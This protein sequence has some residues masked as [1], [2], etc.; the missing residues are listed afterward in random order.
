MSVKR[1]SPL[2]LAAR[3]ACS[4]LF[5]GGGSCLAAS[6]SAGFG[7][8]CIV[9]HDGSVACWGEN[10]QGQA[11]Q[12]STSLVVAEPSIVA[13]LAGAVDLASGIGHS[14]ALLDMG[15]VRCWGR[16]E[17]GALGDGSTAHRAT[18][19]TVGTGTG[20]LSGVAGLGAGGLHT[21]ARLQDGSAACWGFNGSGQLGS[22]DIANHHDATPVAGLSD[23]AEIAAGLQHTCARVDDGRVFCWGSNSLGQLGRGAGGPSISP[24]PVTGIDDA[25]ALAARGDH[26]CVVRAGGEAWCWGSNE[27]RQ[28]GNGNA[29]TSDVPLRVTHVD[30]VNAIAAG[31]FNTCAVHDGGKVR[32]WGENNDSQS[33]PGSGADLELDGVARELALGSDHGCARLDDGSAWCWGRN[34]QAQLGTGV[35]GVEHRTSPVDVLS[36]DDAAQ[37]SAGAYH[38]CVRT[39]A[40]G[41]KCWGLNNFGQL[42]DGSTRSRMTPP[43]AIPGLSG[44]SR[45]SVGS[46]FG[47]LI[48]AGQ[49]FCLGRNDNGQL[50]IGTR[51]DTPVTAPRAVLGLAAAADIDS[52]FGHAC[53]VAAGGSVR[54]WGNNGFGQLGDGTTE[55]SETPVTVIGVS[56]ATAVAVGGAHSCALVAGGAARCWGNG[57]AGQLGNGEIRVEYATAQPVTGLA[58]AV[59]IDAGNGHVCVL[60]GDGSVLCWGSNDARQIG[61]AALGAEFAVPTPVQ[62]LAGVVE[63]S[64]GNSHTCARLADGTARCWGENAQAQLGIGAIG[65]DVAMPTAVAGLADVVSISAGEETSCAVRAT[66]ATVCWGYAAMG[67]LGNG[68]LERTREPVLVLGTSPEVFV[69]GFETLR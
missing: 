65:S 7:F 68:E 3:I 47:C 12:G 26:T 45:L 69:D 25:V 42:G 27:D 62:S 51:N 48:A 56:G 9:L 20:P 44:V 8:G 46:Q 4:L 10:Q 32:C 15:E 5:L 58:G 28:L 41:V 38:A 23:V 13:G 11:G 50:G 67:L 16:N 63:V 61:A 33:G 1:S 2:R 31:L 14:C 17:S 43:V 53:A 57:Y 18:P 66:G 19:V 49:P 37:V 54:C 21:C 30:D 59:A 29:P 6:L 24:V 39:T 34:G 40:G 35:A 55:S 64:T 22:G 52:G 36:L 60:T